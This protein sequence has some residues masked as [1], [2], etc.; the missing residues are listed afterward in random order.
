MGR[1]ANATPQLLYPQKRDP[2]PITQE[3][4]WLQGRFGR[5]RIF[6]PTEFRAP[7]IQVRIESLHRLGYLEQGHHHHQ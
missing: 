3:T 7:A 2:V 1:V 5:V 4:M 6:R